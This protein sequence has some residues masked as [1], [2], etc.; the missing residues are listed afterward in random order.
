MTKRLCFIKLINKLTIL[1]YWC[2]CFSQSNRD[3]LNKSPPNSPPPNRRTVSRDENV[4]SRLT[5][6]TTQPIEHQRSKGVIQPYQGKVSINS[7]IA[8]S[9]IYKVY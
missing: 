4:F 5:S 6:S 2:W 7:K 9:E 1:T 3:R 8:L